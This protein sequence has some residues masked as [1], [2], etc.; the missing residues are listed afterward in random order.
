[1]ELQVLPPSPLRLMRKLAT[2]SE[3][4]AAEPA[5]EAE[6]GVGD[7]G[8]PTETTGVVTALT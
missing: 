4:Q 3:E 8:K 5:S 2:R 7:A 1:M 6:E